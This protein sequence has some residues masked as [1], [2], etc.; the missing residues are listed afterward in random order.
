[1]SDVPPEVPL[2]RVFAM[3]DTARSNTV[4]GRRPNMVS[5]VWDTEHRVGQ[6]H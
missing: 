2:G 6:G 5:K 3:A 4:A 1:M